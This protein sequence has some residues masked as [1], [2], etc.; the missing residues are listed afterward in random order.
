MNPRFFC[1]YAG[2]FAIA[3]AILF[4][5]VRLMR[6]VLGVT[7]AIIPSLMATLKSLGKFDGNPSLASA[8]LVSM[9]AL[10]HASFAPFAS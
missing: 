10:L 1:F 7:D 2:N 6:Y 4:H 9:S 5:P 8:N 3:S